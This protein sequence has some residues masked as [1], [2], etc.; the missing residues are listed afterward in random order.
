MHFILPTDSHAR[1][2]FLNHT[3]TAATQHVRLDINIPSKPAA[4][5]TLADFMHG[6]AMIRLA[7]HWKF[8]PKGQG[9]P[10]YQMPPAEPTP[11]ATTDP[12][13]T[14][15]PEAVAE[16]MVTPTAND[17]LDVLTKAGSFNT[18]I[19]ALNKA[20]LAKMLTEKGRLT[21]FAPTDEAFAA[22]GDDQLKALIADPTKL[23]D[24][25]QM[26]IAAGPWP[27]NQFTGATKSSP[28]TLSSLD[29]KP[30][31][32][33]KEKG[34]IFV[35]DRAVTSSDVKAENGYIHVLAA[36]IGLEP[37]GNRGATTTAPTAAPTGRGG[38]DIIATIQASGCCAIFLSMVEKAGMTDTL[39]TEAYTVFAPPDKAYDNVWMNMYNGHPAETGKRHVTEHLIAEVLPMS[40]FKGEYVDKVMVSGAK[41]RVREKPAYLDIAS[42]RATKPETKAKNGVVYFVDRMVNR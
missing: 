4:E 30:I 5:Q 35:E 22:L 18:F 16:P 6:G 12:G 41:V 29:G 26:H 39:R 8:D 2:C 23:R 17:L 32:I 10:G 15:A 38:K 28:K 34:K 14:L 42:A 13:P 24:V 3:V 25:L 36:V 9:T 19:K 37:G 20:G 31:R 7:Y 21:I 11:E 1:I 33:R 27:S 40:A